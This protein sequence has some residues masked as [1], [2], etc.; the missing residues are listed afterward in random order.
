MCALNHKMAVLGR[1][2][3]HYCV[4]NSFQVSCPFRAGNP[5]LKHKAAVSAK[6]KD[7]VAVNAKWVATALPRWKARTERSKEQPASKKPRR[8]SCRI[9][10]ADVLQILQ[11]ALKETPPPSVRQVIKRTNHEKPIIYRHFGEQCHAIAQRFA[12]SRK[13]QAVARRHR[14]RVEVR[15]AAYQL[16]ARGVEII[17]KHSLHF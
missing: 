14:A 8:P 10:P 15:R 13:I 3:W 1:I 6:E 12:G 16:H 17:R 11:T 5:R 9:K 4:R 7:K 2:K